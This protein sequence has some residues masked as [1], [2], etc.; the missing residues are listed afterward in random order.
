MTK[1]YTVAVIGA[2]SLVGETLLEILADR[3]FPVSKLYALAQASLE[4]EEVDFGRRTLD[5]QDI[6]S[7]DFTEVELAFFIDAALAE[8]YGEEAAQAGCVVIDLSGYFSK[9]LDIPLIVPEVNPQLIE[10][11]RDRNIVANPLSTTIQLLLALKPLHDVA[12]ITRINITTYQAVS[13]SG[14]SGIDELAGQTAQLLNGRPIDTKLYPKQIAFNVLPQIN[15]FQDNG[16]TQDE[17]QLVQELRTILEQPTLGVN[18][19][20]VRVPVFFGD[21]MAV[22]LET[23]QKL[24]VDQAYE[25]LKAASGLSLIDTSGD[26]GYPTAVTEGANDDTVW[27]GRVREDYSH[28]N[29]LNLWLVADNVRKGAALNAVQIAELLVNIQE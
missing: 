13:G 17:N 22:H 15:D 12:R 26:G 21:S 18:P 28:P 2:K 25:V 10:Q 4:D 20:C 16:Y 23:E 24:T 11:Y 5:L 8:T 19:T 1:K 9:Q 29:G 7:F 14:R 3:D 27:V 6:A